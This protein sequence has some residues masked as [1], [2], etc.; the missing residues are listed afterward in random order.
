MFFIPVANLVLLVCCWSQSDAEFRTKGALTLVSAIAWA[1]WFTRDL[2][3]L[4]AVV[5]L[6]VD[7]LLWWVTFG[8]N[9]PGRRT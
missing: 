3:I 2:G 4:S 9:L 8:P 6:V 5:L 7:G 1:S